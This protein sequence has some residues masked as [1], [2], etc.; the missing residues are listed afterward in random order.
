M[1]ERVRVSLITFEVK[2]HPRAR[3]RKEL[4]SEFPSENGSSAR[5]GERPTEKKSALVMF[6]ERA[7]EFV[8]SIAFFNRVLIAIPQHSEVFDA[9]VGG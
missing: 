6:D 8:A 9:D 4:T 5:V 7:F 3:G 2:V 1:G